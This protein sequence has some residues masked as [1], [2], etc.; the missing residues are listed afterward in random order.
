MSDSFVPQ[1]KLIWALAETAVK[2]LDAFQ[3]DQEEGPLEHERALTVLRI[4]YLKLLLS[5]FEAVLGDEHEKAAELKQLMN[6]LAQDQQ[7][8]RRE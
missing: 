2:V 5:Y 3:Q 7:R 4:K 8:K 6:E 1:S